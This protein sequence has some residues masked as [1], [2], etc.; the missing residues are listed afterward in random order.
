[1][2]GIVVQKNVS[3]SGALTPSTTAITMISAVQADVAGTVVFKDGAGVERLH[4]VFGAPGFIVLP[5][6]GIM[7]QNGCNITLTGVTNC[8][9]FYRA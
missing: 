9:V 6:D 5:G 3:V 4:L 2:E 8:G 7:C 1:M